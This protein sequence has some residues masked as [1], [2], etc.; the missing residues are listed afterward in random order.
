VPVQQA[1]SRTHALDVR[2]ESA[3]VWA[4]KLAAGK[5][6]DNRDFVLD[7]RLSGERT[8]AGLLA[9]RDARGGFFSLLVEPPTAPPDASV[10]PREMVFLLDCSG[11]MNGLP[12]E[13]SKA[14]MRAALHK[15]RPSDAFRIVRFSD[16]ATEF[17]SQPLLA[18]PANV[19]R[20]IAYTD[21]LDGEGGTM[22]STGI[23]QALA[24][25]PM[26]G[27]LRIVTFLTDGY[28]GNE[29]E[30]LA[31]I[32]QQLRGARLYAFG[33]GTAVNRYLLDEIGRVGRGFTRHMDPTEDVQRVA[34]ELSDKLQSPLLTDISVDWGELA[35]EQVY[36]EKIPDLFGG[37]SLRVQGRYARPGT[38]AI[39]VRGEA[40]GQPV[41]LPL[42]I[43]LPARAAGEDA[44]ALV[45]A[46]SAIAE[47]LRRMSTP[48][49]SS[50]GPALD[51][52]QRQITDLGLQFSLV[53]RWTSFVAVSEQVYNSDAADTP[54]RPVP[55]PMVEGVGLK[56]YPNQQPFTG[57]AGPEPPVWFGLGLL[58]LLGAWR[59]R[60]RRQAVVLRNF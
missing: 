25:P 8:Q 17:S 58:G 18:T 47:R 55:L 11:S 16:S 12:L 7:Y 19:E 51:A 53:T 46:R 24:P 45:W 20:G 6:V 4:L 22:M 36:P 3:R 29:Q 2:T 37:Q 42:V 59:L 38:Y 21:A 48:E 10:V 39:E 32:Q 14:F 56:A 13:A 27:Y 23:A 31:L 40:R 52:L 44:V 35:P 49:N 33:V 26:L 5:V 28:I 34:A 54:T 60:D 9:H 43:R 41:R 57:A 30:I 1:L 50:N 15:L